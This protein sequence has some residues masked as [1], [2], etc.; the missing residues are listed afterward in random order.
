MGKRNRERIAR[1]LA[2]EEGSRSETVASRVKDKIQSIG[3]RT[4]ESLSTSKQVEVLASSLHTGRVSSSKL[5]SCLK[6]NAVT[7][8]Q[9]GI[10]KLAKKGK[11]PTVDLLLEEY[12]GDREFQKLASEVGLDEEWFIQLAKTECQ[13]WEGN[14]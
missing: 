2:G 10:K 12:R 5:R 4:L 13:K 3:Q 1:I 9:K 8:M 6:A 14:K 11:T 7:E